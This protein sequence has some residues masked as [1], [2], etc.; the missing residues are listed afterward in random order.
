VFVDRDGTLIREREYLADPAKVE[1]LP[2]VVEGLAA[3]TAAGLV[4]VIVTN[5]S[6]IARGY[7]DESA[8]RAVQR[9]VLAALER[10]G[11]TV[12]ASYHC[13]HH[14]EHTGPC[15]CR[16]PADG[17]FRQAAEAHG[18]DL[19]ASA[20]VGDRLRDVEPA[21][22]YGALG[23]LVRT[24]YG[25]GEAERAPGWVVI[26]QDMLDAAGTIIASMEGVDGGRG[27]G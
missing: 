7:F 12:L 19:A 25:A 18:L 26:A 17:L 22:P 1:L 10:G 8:Y 15:D 13:P 21:R 3:L 27:A 4:V 9:E 14:P 16:K 23:I 20:F 11:V 5:Q 2:G 24:G 6:G